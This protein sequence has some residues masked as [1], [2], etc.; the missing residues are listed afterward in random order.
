MLTTL[1]LMWGAL[2]GTGQPVPDEIGRIPLLHALPSTGGSCRAGAP[3]GD[4]MRR[5]GITRT[6]SWQGGSDERLVSVS[7]DA[8]DQ[9]RLLMVIAGVQIGPRKR[10]HETLNAQF[11]P[12][13]RLVIGRRSYATTGTPANLS[14]DRRSGLLPSDSGASAALARSVVERCR[15]RRG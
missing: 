6:Y 11:D 8:K 15:R 5:A 3:T 14:E 9:P 10:A 13:G 1:L 4:T 2:V 7:T 12:N